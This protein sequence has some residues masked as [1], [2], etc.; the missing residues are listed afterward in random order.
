MVVMDSSLNFI[1]A[2]IFGLLASLAMVVGVQFKHKARILIC[3]IIGN[4][5]FILN[6]GLLGAWSGTMVSA[7]GIIVALIIYTLEKHGKT[8]TP[9]IGAVF[10]LAVLVICIFTYQTPWDLLS[11]GAAVVWILS[12][13]QKDENRMR[14]LLL[15]N[16]VMWGIYSVAVMAYTS[17]LADVFSGTSTIIA[18]IRYRNV[19]I[20]KGQ[21]VKT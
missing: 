5:F 7:L 21:N 10:I 6:M 20:K 14:W 2:Q 3:I 11:I 17:V 19:K 16:Y 1:I 13:C 12:L 18:L 4:G 15:I 8:I 9:L